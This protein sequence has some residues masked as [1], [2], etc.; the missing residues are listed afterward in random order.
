MENVSTD[1]Q[2]VLKDEGTRYGYEAAG[3]VSLVAGCQAEASR[4]ALN[5]EQLVV[6]QL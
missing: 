2:T 1:T 5:T 4:A 3:V 6:Q